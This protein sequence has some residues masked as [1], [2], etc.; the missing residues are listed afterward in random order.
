M[1]YRVAAFPLNVPNSISL[2]T[3]IREVDSRSLHTFPNS[4]AVNL[5]E[6]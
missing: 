6:I 4:D 2:T 3:F 1:P 5:N